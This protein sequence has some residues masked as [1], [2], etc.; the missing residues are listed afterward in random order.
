M[1]GFAL[2]RLGLPCNEP[3]SAVFMKS[4]SNCAE[5]V[6]FSSD[7]SKRRP[8]ILSKSSCSLYFP[9]HTRQ[10]SEIVL[11]N[12]Y[13]GFL[14]CGKFMPHTVPICYFVVILAY[15]IV[16]HCEHNQFSTDAIIYNRKYLFLGGITQGLV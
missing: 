6:S 10:R 11:L 1:A 4:Y 16:K 3:A 7:S 5:L 14:V 8:G 2:D 13:L 12:D 9:L 15:V